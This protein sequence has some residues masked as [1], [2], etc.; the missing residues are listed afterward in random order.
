M[1]FSLIVLALLLTGCATPGSLLEDEPRAVV[2]H[3]KAPRDLAE[4]VQHRLIMGDLGMGLQVSH[5]EAESL[6][7]MPIYGIGGPQSTAWVLR[8]RERDASVHAISTI[9]GYQGEHLPEMIEACAEE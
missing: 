8:I 7:M 6:L 9:S 5:G 2:R 1:R 4:C 3:E